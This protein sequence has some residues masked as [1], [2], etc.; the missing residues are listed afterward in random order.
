MQRGKVCVILCKV[1]S[2]YSHPSGDC[3][4][5]DNDTKLTKGLPDAGEIVGIEVL[6]RIIFG[7]KNYLSLKR[8]VLF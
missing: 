4:A 1:V 2:V 3:T 7:D 6:D 5:L 8:E